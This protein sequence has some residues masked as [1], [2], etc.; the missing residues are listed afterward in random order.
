MRAPDDASVK[1]ALRNLKKFEGA[2]VGGKTLETRPEVLEELG[3]R[4]ELE[5]EGPLSG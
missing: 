2:T 3:I 4:G 5:F 1:L